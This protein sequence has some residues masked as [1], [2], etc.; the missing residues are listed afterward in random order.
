MESLA[1]LSGGKSGRL[2]GSAE[3]I[4]MAVMAML[5]KLKGSEGVKAYMRDYHIG[6]RA[7]EFG[8]LLLEGPKK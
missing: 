4:D 1:S 2:D 5:A 3:M 7:A 8:Q 6:S